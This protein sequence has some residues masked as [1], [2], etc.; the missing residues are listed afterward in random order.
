M[1]TELSKASLELL[2]IHTYEWGYTI[3]GYYSA[4][5]SFEHHSTDDKPLF[6]ACVSVFLNRVNTYLLN[7]P[8]YRAKL[9]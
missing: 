3:I 1:F 4:Y 6:S 9:I 5:K 7:K 8:L 2:L